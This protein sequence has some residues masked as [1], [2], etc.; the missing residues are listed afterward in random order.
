MISIYSIVLPRLEAPYLD[1]WV[2]YHLNLGVDNIYLYNNGLFPVDYA[3]AHWKSK[4]SKQKKRKTIIK[5]INPA[6]RK[7]IWEKKPCSDYNF[8]MSD[9]QIMEK[10][11]GLE[12]RWPQVK[13]VSWING[14]DHG[15]PYP[16]SQEKGLRH[17]IGNFETDWVLFIDPDEFIGLDKHTSL[18]SFIK[19]HEDVKMF[20]FFPVYCRGRTLETSMTR[21]IESRSRKID[22][23]GPS[24]WL[25]QI[26]EEKDLLQ[27]DHAHNVCVENQEGKTRVREFRW[28]NSPELVY[29]HFNGPI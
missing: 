26:K 2:E 16:V 1:E 3:G 19:S 21:A 10:F 11:A 22:K 29:F 25:A 8:H 23:L 12:S 9:E 4:A 17:F 13:I 20:R 28:I 14:M 15:Y 18:K 27:Y 7:Y 6:L 5:R 24:K